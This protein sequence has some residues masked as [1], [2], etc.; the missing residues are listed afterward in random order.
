MPVGPVLPL[1]RGIAPYVIF[2][3]RKE[4]IPGGPGAVA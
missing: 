3:A 1:I 4:A 2:R